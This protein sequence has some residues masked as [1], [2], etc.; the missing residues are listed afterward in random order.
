MTSYRSIRAL[1]GAVPPVVGAEITIPETFA[2]WFGLE[3]LKA[4]MTGQPVG[5]I[6]RSLRM[7]LLA[8]YNPLGL[9][10]TP[11]CVSNLHLEV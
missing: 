6:V 1:R 3:F 7:E 9:A 5:S 8:R 10:Y 2:K 11:Y 4:F